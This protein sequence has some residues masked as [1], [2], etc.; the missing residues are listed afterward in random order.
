MDNVY[1]SSA[2]SITTTVIDDTGSDFQYIGGAG[3]HIDNTNL[4]Q[5]LTY[6]RYVTYG[7]NGALPPK[8]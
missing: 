7:L 5:L 2:H 8:S 1:I 4:G 6:L 3:T